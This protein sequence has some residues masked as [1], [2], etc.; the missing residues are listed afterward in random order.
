MEIWVFIA[1]ILGSKYVLQFDYSFEAQPLAV[2]VPM[3][4]YC[5]P[6]NHE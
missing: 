4:M 2:G 5:E 1:C 6:K 3:F